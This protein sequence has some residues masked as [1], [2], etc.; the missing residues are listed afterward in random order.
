MKK[1]FDLKLPTDAAFFQ[2]SMLFLCALEKWSQTFFCSAAE[3]TFSTILSGGAQSRGVDVERQI[4][5]VG[6]CLETIEL[7]CKTT[8]I[9]LEIIRLLFRD[10]L[11]SVAKQLKFVSRQISSHDETG[12]RQETLQSEA[13]KVW[14]LSFRGTRKFPMEEFASSRALL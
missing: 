13:G 3:N 12:Q 10:G 6:I 14:R 7:R 8:K 11:S 2:P 1:R 5:R 9:C 4:P